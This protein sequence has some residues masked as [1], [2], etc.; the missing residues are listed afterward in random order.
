MESTAVLPVSESPVDL[1]Q[2]L[3]NI[4][5]KRQAI[6]R[7]QE[8][9]Q[10][11]MV[12]Y[13]AG[14]LDF[15]KFATGTAVDPVIN[16]NVS[17]LFQKYAN[18]IKQNKGESLSSLLMDLSQ[19]VNGLKNYSLTA[20]QIRANIEQRSKELA[21][22]GKDW[23]ANGLMKDAMTK[24]FMKL[25]PTTGK[26]VMK[27]AEELDPNADYAGQLLTTRPELYN[28]GQEG[29]WKNI[30]SL[31][32]ASYGEST[33]IYARPGVKVK[34]SWEAN[35]LLPFQQVVKDKD[36]I[37]TGTQ[38]K[39]E[40]IEFKRP[41]GSKVKV[42]ALP[43][44]VY[45][46]IIGNT[47]NSLYFNA[48]FNKYLKQV[49]P[50]I[51]PHSPEADQLKRVYAY[52][53]LK[54]RYPDNSNFKT[55]KDEQQ[56]TYVIKNQLGIPVGGKG[57]SNSKSDTE[58]RDAYTSLD[59]FTTNARKRATVVNPSEITSSAQELITTALAKIGFTGDNAY[60]P[61]DYFLYKG[62]DGKIGVFRWDDGDPT[63]K[64]PIIDT[65][66]RLTIIDPQD[67]NI[68]ANQP[69]GPK[70]KNK[71]AENTSANTPSK[72]SKKEIKGF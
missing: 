62:S 46:E 2:G 52:D 12:K 28:K 22:D 57:G 45:D 32:K 18:R 3:Q 67:Y 4:Q 44:S 60:A 72:S 35:N 34:G 54:A 66:H 33:G 63:H 30:E 31:P 51:N 26:V 21:G 27:S 65:N 38:V 23:E 61:N 53:Q 50:N 29:Y 68:K 64:K 19:D 24:A 59:K 15:S 58:W 25:D 48:D 16:D 56:S 40:M 10:D 55:K 42:P 43:Q 17:A 8:S 39:N 41:D 36:G 9:D 13:M 5:A 1:A 49:N 6:L 70:A 20:K 47:Q 71:A 69:L 37:A 11:E 7:K 14:Q